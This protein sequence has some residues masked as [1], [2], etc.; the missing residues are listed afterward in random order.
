MEVAP[1]VYRLPVTLYAPPVV[2]DHRSTANIYLLRGRDGCMLI[3]SGWDTESARSALERQF[4][5]LGL[6]L[7]D[8]S[9][10]IYTHLHPDHFGMSGWF[11]E[12]GVV[13]QAAHPIEIEYVRNRYF[14]GD[15]VLWQQEGQWCQRHGVPPEHAAD[16]QQI[17]LDIHHLV[18]L[19][20]PEMT[21]EVGDTI[22][23]APFQ[24]K[25]LGTPGHSPG[26]VC[27]YEPRMKLLFCGDH[28]TNSVSP[29]I[30][31]Y[32]YY[33]DDV[34]PLGWYLDS[35]KSLDGLDAT[36]VMPAH[37]RE[38]GGLQRRIK[39]IGPRLERMQEQV[40]ET[41]EGQTLTAF[42]VIM[43]QTRRADWSDIPPIQKRG[44]LVETVTRLRA[45]KLDGRVESVLNDGVESFRRTDREAAP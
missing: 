5:E 36:L 44:L 31:F 21:L 25:V 42:E 40:L 39:Q 12:F 26:H 22:E 6:G 4:A 10:I 23:F 1:G 13:R 7:R 27:F 8:I 2:F 14:L 17:A 29:H 38:F 19:Q 30:P 41:L 11:K 35:L 34:N 45:L 37:G 32:S 33:G 18:R 28:I 15:E 3:D 24:L 43:H 20:V 9:Q 16:L